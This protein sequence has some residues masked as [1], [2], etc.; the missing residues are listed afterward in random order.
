M[1][2]DSLL[3][4]SN[5]LNLTRQEFTIIEKHVLIL[6]LLKLK[7][8]QSF[9][10]DFDIDNDKVNIDLTIDASE[11]KEGNRERIKEAIGKLTSRKIHFDNSTP[12]K[13][14]F[15]YII[16]FIY[17]RYESINGVKSEINLMVHSKCKK[18]FLNLANGYTTMDLK[19]ILSLKST[20]SIRMYELMSM[21]KTQASWTVEINKLKE[22]LGLGY[23]VYKNFTDFKRYVLE[24]SQKELWEHCNIHFEWEVAAKQRK[25]VTAL[26]FHIKERNKQEKEELSEEIKAT[27]DYITGLSPADIKQK[28]GWVKEKYTLTDQQFEYILADNAVFNEFI[29][30]D[31]IIEDKIIKGN[32]PRDRTKYLAK[33]LGLDKVKFP[34]KA[35]SD[36]PKTG[37]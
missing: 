12:D 26:T 7:E 11:I 37:K 21:Y 36:K 9:D 22:L 27:Q 14:Y 30:I 20:H 8:Q 18:L 28:A 29:R 13:D 2:K 23:D 17:A 33:S 31:L 34:K 15:G 10:L 6:T 19:A 35:K 32:P 16:P 1:K 24:Y 5:V 4:I 25:K 3:R